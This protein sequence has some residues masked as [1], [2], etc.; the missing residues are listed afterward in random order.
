MS[1]LKRFFCH[2]FTLGFIALGLGLQGADWPQY[3]GP[4]RDAVYPDEALTRAWPSD[5]PKV[6]WR[7]RDIGAGMSGVVVAG[8]RVVLF[9]EVNRYDTI[10]CLDAKS[11]KS[12][13]KNSY[14]S[15]V[16]PGYGSA[17]GP[18]APPARPSAVPPRAPPLAPGEGL[19]YGLRR[20]E[21]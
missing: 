1:L 14:A 20:Q 16:V 19:G 13:W 4:G 5:G 10:D 9:H 21:A 17:A 15:S 7:K 11:G 8:G 3:L 12:I 2:L 18:R 6:L